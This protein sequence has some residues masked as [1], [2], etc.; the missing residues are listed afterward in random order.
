[1]LEQAKIDKLHD[2]NTK[3]QRAYNC[4]HAAVI[5]AIAGLSEESRLRYSLELAE[6]RAEGY[7]SDD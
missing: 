6:K 2:E 5:S 3:L 4:L 7:L 1:M